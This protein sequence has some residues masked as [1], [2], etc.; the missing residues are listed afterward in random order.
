MRYSLLEIKQGH[1]HRVSSQLEYPNRAPRVAT[2][3]EEVTSKREVSYMHFIASEARLDTFPRRLRGRLGCTQA[4]VCPDYIDH[5]DTKYNKNYLKPRKIT[6]IATCPLFR[7]G[8]WVE[9]S[10]ATYK[11]SPGDQS[12]R[13]IC[14]NAAWSNAQTQKSELGS[15]GR[16]FTCLAL[17][18]A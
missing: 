16:S 13:R 11:Q 2:C 7:E 14:C 8:G 10:D 15:T 18:L 9:K 5:S 4:I 3:P 1:S 12:R 17:S 6:F